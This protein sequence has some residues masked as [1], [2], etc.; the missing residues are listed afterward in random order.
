MLSIPQ[1]RHFLYVLTESGTYFWPSFQAPYDTLEA[2]TELISAYRSLHDRFQQDNLKLL[3]VRRDNECLFVWS[4]DGV[5][6]YLALEPLTSPEDALECKS[7]IVAWI[8]KQE[9]L[10]MREDFLF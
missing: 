2:K 10:L 3:F 5:E 9:D 4:R 1:L 8:S 6:L 7:K